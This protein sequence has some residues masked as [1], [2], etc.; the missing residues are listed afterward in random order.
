MK[1]GITLFLLVAFLLSVD[2]FPQVSDTCVR[3]VVKGMLFYES[4]RD[5]IYVEYYSD[6]LNVKV[7]CDELEDDSYMDE[8]ASIFSKNKCTPR[9]FFVD[10]I[11]YSKEVSRFQTLFPSICIIHSPVYFS[12]H[13]TL[14]LKVDKCSKVKDVY[15]EMRKSLLFKSVSFSWVIKN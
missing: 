12:T 13:G 4:L 15:Q 11:M 2:V 3:H 9:S 14:E 1:S 10:T 7:I 6:E 5:S 8:I